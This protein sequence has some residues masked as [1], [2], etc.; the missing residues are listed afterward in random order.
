RLG[1]P[2]ALVKPLSEPPSLL[3][4]PA[5]AAGQ[6]LAP[7]AQRLAQVARAC[8]LRERVLGGFGCVLE[9]GPGATELGEP[10]LRLGARRLGLRLRD[11]EPVQLGRQPGE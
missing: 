5:F 1:R 6:L 11:R 4:E 3:V 9:R 2:L 8:R 7:L 10:R